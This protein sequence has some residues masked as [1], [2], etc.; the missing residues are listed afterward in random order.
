MPLTK[1]VFSLTYK[2]DTQTPKQKLKNF[3]INR[4]GC[5]PLL[6]RSGRTS[7]CGI[8]IDAP[9]FYRCGK[10]LSALSIRSVVGGDGSGKKFNLFVVKREARTRAH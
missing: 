6:F 1:I 4:W 7:P 3:L 5:A 10:Q 8:K 2:I 9:C